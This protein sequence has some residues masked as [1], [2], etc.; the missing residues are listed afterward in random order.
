[1]VV[2]GDS[3][4]K[5]MSFNHSYIMARLENMDISWVV[6]SGAKIKYHTGLVNKAQDADVA[7][8][9]CGGNDLARS[10]PSAVCAD[11]EEFVT[12]AK[13]VGARSVVIMGYFKRKTPGYNDKVQQL[14]KA[15]QSL[16]PASKQA[17]EKTRFWLWDRRLPQ[18]T[19]ADGVHLFSSGY[20]K[21][22]MYFCSAVLHAINVIL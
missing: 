13:A 12:K 5:R 16:Y 7:V 22:A 10:N 8:L 6:K 1:M 2:F 9:M 15:L 21:A 18:G 17:A 19:V 4:G 14:Q 20:R 3:H 11:V